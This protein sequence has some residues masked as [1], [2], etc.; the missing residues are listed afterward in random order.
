[1]T[2]VQTVHVGPGMGQTTSA[3]P[4]ETFRG[5][6]EAYA[7]SPAFVRPNALVAFHPGVYTNYGGYSWMDTIEVALALDVPFILTSFTA[8]DTRCTREFLEAVQVDVLHDKPNP[9]ASPATEQVYLCENLLSNR[10]R[11]LL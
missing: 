7:R 9:F 8:E 3:A 10:N 11:H 1:M 2:P 4:V 5:S 6:Y